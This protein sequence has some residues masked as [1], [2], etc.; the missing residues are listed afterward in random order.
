MRR[1]ATTSQRL[2]DEEHRDDEDDRLTSTSVASRWRSAS[3]SL[4]NAEATTLEL[5]HD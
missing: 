4:G 3:T 5:R 2:K 1:C